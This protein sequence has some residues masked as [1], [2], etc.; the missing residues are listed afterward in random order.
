MPQIRLTEAG[1]AYVPR[2]PSGATRVE[3]DQTITLSFEEWEAVPAGMKNL[4]L[5][6]TGNTAA[7]IGVTPVGDIDSDQLQA[8][9]AELSAEK[10]ATS[11][12]RSARVDVGPI[13][14]VETEVVDVEWAV[15]FEDTSY[16]VTASVESEAGESLVV[17]HVTD[18]SE[19]GVSV[20]VSNVGEVSASGV[21]HVIAIADIPEPE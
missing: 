3:R 21:L 8:V 7:D 2:L 13:A 16:T 11:F 1:V 20:E 17:L 14:T 12:V 5:L 15:P 6:I 19:E 10:L 9:L 4:F 18:V